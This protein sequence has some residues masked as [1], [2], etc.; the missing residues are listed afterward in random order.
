[1]NN[2]DLEWLKDLYENYIMPGRVRTSEALHCRH[3][4][5]LL[6]LNL[7]HKK[8]KEILSNDRHSCL[9]IDGLYIDLEYNAFIVDFDWKTKSI[10]STAIIKPIHP[11]F[12]I[13]RDSIFKFYNT[14][15]TGAY[16]IWHSKVGVFYN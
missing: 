9:S 5:Q 15:A 3:W 13:Y 12:V 7:Q 2:N 8:D 16:N 11:K 10:D 1:M 14:R 6:Y 4:S